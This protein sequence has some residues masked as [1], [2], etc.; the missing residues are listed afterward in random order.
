MMLP[1]EIFRRFWLLTIAI[2]LLACQDD[3]D[4]DVL[5]AERGKLIRYEW[6]NTIA[7]SSINELYIERLDYEGDISGLPAYNIDLY[8]IVYQSIH[9]DALVELSG[10]IVVPDRAGEIAHLQYHHGTMFPYPFPEGEGSLDAPSLYD[11]APVTEYDAHAE[12]RI[13]GNY[14]GSYGYLVSLPDYAGY[15]ASAHLEHPYSVNTEL[16]KQ[17]VDM[18]IATQQFCEQL[19]IT[20]N[21]HLFMAGW[22]EGAAASVATQ[23][24]MQESYP[25]LSITANAPLAGFYNLSYYAD[26]MLTFLPG[27]DLDFG[28]DLDVLIWTLYTMNKFGLEPLDNDQLFKYSVNRD[29]DVLTE[30]PS[31]KPSQ[32][33]KFLSNDEK[34]QFMK[35][36]RYNSLAHGWAPQAPVFVHHGT[37]DDIVYYNNNAALAV[38]NWNRNGG[39]AQLYSY[40]NHNHYSLVMLYL[41]NMI[42]DFDALQ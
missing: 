26:L 21:D 11:G 42:A 5:L 31:S 9:E 41:L 13:F 27:L 35:S 18:I 6:V 23:H 28:S 32:L 16:A 33:L 34:E 38:D 15:G 25:N 36:F 37:A 22:S 40:A 20:L 14:L 24:L 30:R 19:N 12:A 8:K 17:S 4:E 3:I 10:L 7:A 1:H 29:L 39:N 2:G